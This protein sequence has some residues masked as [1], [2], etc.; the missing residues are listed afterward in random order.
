MLSRRTAR[1]VISLI[2][3]LALLALFSACSSGSED[4]PPSATSLEVAA[5]RGVGVTTIELTDTSRPTEPNRDV[6]GSDERKL[7]V[8]IWY[9][10][11]PSAD[12]PEERSVALD[13]SGAPYPLIVFAHGFSSTRRQS[14]SYTQHLASHGYVVAAP[15]FSASNLQAP[16]GPR[17]VAVLKQP[18]DVSFLI[19]SL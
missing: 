19:G 13:D 17:L 3:A 8:E 14:S 7:A 2:A 15:D 12:V 4:H 16:G 9:P 18:E 5:E 10:A 1:R 6:A 11:D